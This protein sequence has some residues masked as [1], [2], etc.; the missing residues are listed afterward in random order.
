MQARQSKLFW[1]MVASAALMVIGSFGP[2][3]RAFIFTVSG[4]DGGDGWVVVVAAAFAGGM[5][6]LHA[7]RVD[8][9]RW[10]LL[11]AA[12]AGLAAFIVFIIDAK[13]VFGTQ[14]A[15]EDSLFGSTDLVQPGWGLI[16]VGLAS[17]SMILSALATFRTPI[18]AAP[19]PPS[20]AG[21]AGVDPPTAGAP[22]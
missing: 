6:Y 3:V 13:D 19:A 17:L 16:L 1:W 8:R 21:D 22:D 18:G 7:G 15:G 10:P 12:G 9:P 5:I 11:C 14:S 20:V 4:V 2:W